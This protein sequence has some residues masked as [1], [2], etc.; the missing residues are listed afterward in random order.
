MSTTKQYLITEEE[1]RLKS[2]SLIRCLTYENQEEDYDEEDEAEDV[3][4]ETDTEI[5]SNNA[6]PQIDAIKQENDDKENIPQEIKP[7]A[8]LLDHNY[9]EKDEITQNTDIT[10][11]SI[12][13]DMPMPSNSLVFKDKSELMDYI[14]KNLTVDELFER[15]TQAEEESMK[16]KELIE[17]VFRTI[18]MNEL[19]TEILPNSEVKNVKMTPEQTEVTSTI[20]DH[21]SKLMKSNDRV[22]H[23]VLDTLSEKHSKAFLTHALQENSTSAVC[24]KLTIPNIVAYLIHKVNVCENDE[25]DLEMNKMNRAIMHHLLKSTHNNQEIVSDQKE[26]QEL[27]KFLFKNKPKIDILDTVHEFLRDIIQQK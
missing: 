16:R 13:E 20:I 10:T 3:N 1:E 15:L 14:S 11:S 5:N 6:G 26:T 24:E 9:D 2:N 23:T 17:K 27:L 21:I 4:M 25:I 8:I 22:K 12:E 7:Q 18:D 19:L